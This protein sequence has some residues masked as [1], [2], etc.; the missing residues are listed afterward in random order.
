MWERRAHEHDETGHDTTGHSIEN[1]TLDIIQDIARHYWSGIWHGLGRPRGTGTAEHLPPPSA[2]ERSRG[3]PTSPFS[4][5][6]APPTSANEARRRNE[7]L[8][9]LVGDGQ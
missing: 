4:G 6:Q 8:P 9:A 5:I 7:Q 3:T 2:G 1:R